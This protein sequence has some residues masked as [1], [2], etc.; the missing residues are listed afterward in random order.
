M[1]MRHL[2]WMWAIPGWVGP[3]D[4]PTQPRRSSTDAGTYLW[5]GFQ[6]SFLKFLIR[7]STHS[8]S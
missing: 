8:S 7:T 3:G 2:F 1:S 5:S 6:P 4:G